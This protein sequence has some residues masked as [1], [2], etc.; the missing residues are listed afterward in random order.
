MAQ[1]V[2]LETV[3]GIE[4]PGLGWIP[5]FWC[6]LPAL[7]LELKPRKA[8]SIFLHALQAWWVWK[9]RRASVLLIQW[10]HLG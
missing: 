1:N 3:L 9:L 8:L 7:Q 2:D 6:F 4:L 5:T 10:K